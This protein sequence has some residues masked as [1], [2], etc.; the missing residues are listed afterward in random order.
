MLLWLAKYQYLCFKVIFALKILL[1]WLV[2]YRKILISQ[3][4]V[5]TKEVGHLKYSITSI[6]VLFSQDHIVFLRIVGL[7]YY[8][9]FVFIS[10]GSR[11]FER[12][13]EVRVGGGHNH[14]KKH[15]LIKYCVFF[16]TQ[17]G[18]VNIDIIVQN[19]LFNYTYNVIYIYIQQNSTSI[20]PWLVTG[21]STVRSYIII[22][23]LLYL[24]KN[25]FVYKSMRKK[26][27]TYLLS[28]KKIYT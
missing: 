21:V 4:A 20:Y 15:W 11:I 24:L 19:S 14:T 28:L 12:Q 9:L 16:G 5:N 1:L 25:L 3:P 10:G 7:P 22:W 8:I 13:F 2:K 23:T 26:S 6:N 27:S 18:K 17:K